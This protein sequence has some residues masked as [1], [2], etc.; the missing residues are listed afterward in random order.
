MSDSPQNYA[1]LGQYSSQTTL[2][3]PTPFLLESGIGTVVFP[4]RQHNP[5]NYPQIFLHRCFCSGNHTQKSRQFIL[6]KGRNL[7]EDKAYPGLHFPRT[8]RSK[9]WVDQ[10]QG[11][12]CHSSWESLC[13]PKAFI[14]LKLSCVIQKDLLGSTYLS[15]E[16]YFLKHLSIPLPAPAPQVLFLT[17][18][19]HSSWTCYTA[20]ENFEL[21]ISLPP[22]P[23][24]EGTAYFGLGF[25]SSSTTCRQVASSLTFSHRKCGDTL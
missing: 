4:N 8:A 25:S 20:E 17:C 12:F 2:P 5:D 18:S 24:T 16:V 21:L 11:L 9:N 19:S 13:W 1:P 7:W 6:Y 15:L 3:T 22:L 14:L 23:S 10:N